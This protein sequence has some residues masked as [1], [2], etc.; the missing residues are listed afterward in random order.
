MVQK[1]TMTT[2]MKTAIV[3][4]QEIHVTTKVAEMKTHQASLTTPIM[5]AERK[6][7]TFLTSLHKKTR[8]SLRVLYLYF[9]FANLSFLKKG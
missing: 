6:N 3:V 4:I 2:I 9:F 1:E 8:N 5:E 7:S